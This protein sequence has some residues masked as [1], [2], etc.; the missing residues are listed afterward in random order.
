MKNRYLLALSLLS[1]TAFFTT[2]VNI[3]LA[4]R[5]ELFGPI[6]RP[7]AF[8]TVGGESLYIHDSIHKHMLLSRQQAHVVC[9]H[10]MPS[11]WAR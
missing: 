3:K 9:T 10:H 8:P 11:R 5:L 6:R 1:T 7:Y 4:Q 2:D